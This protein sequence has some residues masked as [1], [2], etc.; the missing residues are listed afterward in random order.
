MKTKKKFNEEKTMNFFCADKNKYSCKRFNHG[1]FDDEIICRSLF[2]YTFS[3]KIQS[4]S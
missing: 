1:Y 4:Y 2:L 3:L